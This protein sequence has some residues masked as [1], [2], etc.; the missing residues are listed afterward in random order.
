[1]F[2]SFSLPFLIKNTTNELF[3]PQKKDL[4]FIF[5]FCLM[6]F[7]PLC[8][9]YKLAQEKKEDYGVSEK[10]SQNLNRK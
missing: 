1:M 9:E 6:S 7:F 2:L 8:M 10:E 3:F 5:V 4:F